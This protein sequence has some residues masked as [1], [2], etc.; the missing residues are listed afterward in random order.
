MGRGDSPSVHIYFFHNHLNSNKQLRDYISKGRMS[1]S[2]VVTA[3][4]CINHSFLE[5]RGDETDPFN[6]TGEKYSTA[7][8][9]IL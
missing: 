6:G 9:N 1:Y 5:G 2:H 3:R 4:V 8:G 7:K